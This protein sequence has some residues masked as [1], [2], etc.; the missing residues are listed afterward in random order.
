MRLL[1]CGTPDFAAV[2][3]GAVAGG[4]HE[5]A[6]LVS[7]PAQPR[8]RGL[9]LEDPPAVAVARAAG[10]PVFQEP[11]LHAPETLDRLRALGPDLIVTAAFGRILRR[12]LLDLAPRG[13]WNVHA[14]LLP[15]HRGASPVAASILC[16]DAW[17]GVTLFRLDEGVDTGPILDQVMVPV[18][19]EETGGTLTECLA[20]LGGELLRQAL[21][22][23]ER[24]E[25]HPRPQPAWGAT[26]APRLTKEDGRIDWNRPVE[27]VERVIR[28]LTPWPGAFTFVEGKRLRVHRAR[29]VHRM[30]ATAAEA[31]AGTLR[32]HGSGVAVACNPGLLE[33]DEVQLE[34]R[35][36]QEAAAWWRGARLPAG[37]R[38]AS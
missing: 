19:P 16:G 14:S 25:L 9:A 29:P 30:P 18:G 32:P 13:A 7:R 38:V 15:R 3:L 10:I 8:G 12:S 34:G 5:V 4:P 28:A 26:Y 21:D 36:R 37:T 23:E 20:R 33:L 11:K 35:A 1:F 27:Q 31:E 6:G 22:R 2:I 17:T 24:G